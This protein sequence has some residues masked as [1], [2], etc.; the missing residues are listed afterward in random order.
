MYMANSWESSLTVT[1]FDGLPPLDR[2]GNV[3]NPSVA[4][5]LSIRLP[6]L[7]DE[8]K[9]RLAIIE[10][11]EKDPPYGAY[12][13][14]DFKAN[15]AAGWNC[16]EFSPNVEEALKKACIANFD[17]K[18]LAHAGMGG[19]IPLLD[20]LSKMFPAADLVVTG[21]LGP[22]TNMHGPNEYL[23]IEYTKKV[24][25][26][27]SMTMGTLETKAKKLACSPWEPRQPPAKKPRPTYCFN[28][29]E[30]PLGMCLCCL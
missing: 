2:A 20:M 18:E 9:A 24:T 26:A 13:N 10:A 15:V 11:F 27:I 8:E 6:P 29:P 5:R 14:A 17:G 30:V 23:P 22:G 21:V 19:T 16:A 7:V 1:G 25:A 28:Y 4:M 3:L 12:V